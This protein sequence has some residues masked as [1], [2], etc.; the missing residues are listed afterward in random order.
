VF[1]G[2][3]KVA[4]DQ[5]DLASGE[6]KRL[7]ERV[8]N[9]GMVGYWQLDEGVIAWGNQILAGLNDKDLIIIDEL[10]PLELE[11]GHGFQQALRLLD[12]RRYRAAVV[13]VRPAL[14]PLARL[15]WPT[16][17]VFALKGPAT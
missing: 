4:I 6:R 15:R 5:I 1:G 16:A 11:D 12:K 10:G 8:R 14:L 13:V 7:G 3:K 17:E 2:G 9:G